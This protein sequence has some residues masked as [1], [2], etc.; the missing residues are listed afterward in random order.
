MSINSSVFRTI[1]NNTDL[2]DGEIALPYSK[3]SIT[4]WL[5]TFHCGAGKSVYLTCRL[6]DILLLNHQYDIDNGTILQ[7]TR[8]YLNRNKLG[9]NLAKALATEL[10]RP[11][12]KALANNIKKYGREIKNDALDLFKASFLIKIMHDA[13]DKSSRI[14]VGVSKLT[15]DTWG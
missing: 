13:D 11:L 9:R 6:G 14:E 4:E 3:E 8:G 1:F 15:A 5:L 12:N 7:I 10:F 2:S